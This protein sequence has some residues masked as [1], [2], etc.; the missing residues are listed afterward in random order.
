MFVFAIWKLVDNRWKGQKY[1]W[2]S[3][4]GNAYF[5][6]CG[7]SLQNALVMFGYGSLRLIFSLCQERQEPD[8]LVVKMAGKRFQADLPG[9]PLRR[10]HSSTMIF[11]CEF[12]RGTLEMMD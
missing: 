8:M 3:F 7:L 11:F 10:F 9:A 12:Y 5:R 2:I 4:I 6:L 1:K